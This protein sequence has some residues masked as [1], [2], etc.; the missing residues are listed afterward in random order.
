MGSSIKKFFQ[1]KIF[2]FVLAYTKKR[3][4]KFTDSKIEFLMRSNIHVVEKGFVENDVDFQSMIFAR[5]FYFEAQRRNL[6]SKDETEWCKRILFGDVQ[7]NI[8][9]FF[10]EKNNSFEDIL[11][12]RRSIRKWEN[13]KITKE[14]FEKLIDAARWAPSSCN[15]QPWHFLIIENKDKI[16]FL[17]R[18]KNQAFIKNAPFC[19]LVLIDLDAY[20]ETTRNYFA[21]LDAGMATQN[22]LLMAENMDLGACFVNL[23]PIDDFESQKKQIKNKFDI[24]SNLEPICIIPIGKKTENFNSPGRKNISDIIHFENFKN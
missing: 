3:I 10:H 19:I 21:L 20:D 24:S 4:S 8:K 23:A 18:I 7:K 9:N 11:K 1:K 2:D 16:K 14:E 17:S 22:I 13:T 12:Q 5:A 6:L 15:R